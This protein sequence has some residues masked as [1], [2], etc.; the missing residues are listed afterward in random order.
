MDED[1]QAHGTPHLVN[2]CPGFLVLKLCLQF[3]GAVL[4]HKR[5]SFRGAV[6]PH[7]GL[8]IVVRDLMGVIPGLDCVVDVI[9]DLG[10]LRLTRSPCL[11]LGAGHGIETHSD[12][13]HWLV[14]H[15]VPQVGH[16]LSQRG[17]LLQ[18]CGG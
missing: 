5:V 10:V 3:L 18:P 12:Q 8:G 14:E 6:L 17:S 16:H 15:R 11:R 9:H 13:L 2:P 7:L 4:E 1:E